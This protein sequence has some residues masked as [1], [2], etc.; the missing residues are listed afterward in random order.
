MNRTI[1]PGQRIQDRLRNTVTEI[2]LVL[3]LA[4]VGKGP[5]AM[6]HSLGFPGKK[7][8]QFILP[9]TFA[10]KFLS[11]DPTHL[12]HLSQLRSKR[13]DTPKRP[14]ETSR[15]AEDLPRAHVRVKQQTNDLEVASIQFCRGYIELPLY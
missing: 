1:T 6:P 3:R 11:P 2:A 10:Q 14:L 15:C 13:A 4:H 8:E 7:V 12:G 5:R 9:G